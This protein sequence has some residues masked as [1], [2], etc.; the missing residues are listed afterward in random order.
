MGLGVWEGVPLVPQWAPSVLLMYLEGWGGPLGGLGR[1]AAPS[2]GV[3]EGKK[4]P[5]L[6]ASA[7]FWFARETWKLICTQNRAVLPFRETRGGGCRSPQPSQSLSWPTLYF[8]GHLVSVALWLLRHCWNTQNWNTS[9]KGEW[10]TL[11]FQWCV[12]THRL[13]STCYWILYVLFW[14][15]IQIQE[16]PSFFL[17]LRTIQFTFRKM[18]V[19][20]IDRL[21]CKLYSGLLAWITLDLKQNIISKTLMDHANWDKIPAFWL[22]SLRSPG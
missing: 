14:G 11:A 18:C 15:N 21:N 20:W 5:I 6:S 17:V 13:G 9:L 1:P 3:P 10:P 7:H 8:K 19:F 16:N 4:S 2:T 12:K 22:W